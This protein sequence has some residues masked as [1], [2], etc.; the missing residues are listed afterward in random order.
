MPNRLVDKDGNGWHHAV[1]K[2]HAI[3]KAAEDMLPEES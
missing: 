1:C 3:C 2:V